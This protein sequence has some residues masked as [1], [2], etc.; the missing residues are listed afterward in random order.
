MLLILFGFLIY[1]EWTITWTQRLDYR[2][3]YDADLLKSA[4]STPPQDV[5]QTGFEE[6]KHRESRRHWIFPS[7]RPHAEP[8]PAPKAEFT[9]TGSVNLGQRHTTYTRATVQNLSATVN[10]RNSLWEITIMLIPLGM[11]LIMFRDRPRRITP[12]TVPIPA[13][14][15]PSLSKIPPSASTPEAKPCPPQ[16][17]PANSARVH[18]ASKC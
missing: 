1:P 17:Q 14:R 15:V 11:F 16:S 18:D 8:L 12:P 6:E 10:K 9:G 5:W 3:Y 4:Q 7:P 13:P 2:Y